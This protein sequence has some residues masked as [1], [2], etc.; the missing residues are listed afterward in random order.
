MPES[1]LQKA[2]R[3]ERDRARKARIKAV[4]QQ[5]KDKP[6]ADCKIKYPYYVMQFDHVRGTKVG[7][8]SRMVAN[9]QLA[10]ILEEL[11]KCDVVCAN[12]HAV[13]TFVRTL[14]GKDSPFYVH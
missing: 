1:D 2:K 3:R 7:D 10:K 11:P 8:I 5:A 13:R 14:V 9:R 6:C 12:C 4:V